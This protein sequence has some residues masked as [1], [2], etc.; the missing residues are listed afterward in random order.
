MQVPLVLLAGGGVSSG[1]VAN[2]NYRTA[3]RAFI[4][5]FNGGSAEWIE[6]PL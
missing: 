5:V 3:D 6:T 1:K 2:F 4:G